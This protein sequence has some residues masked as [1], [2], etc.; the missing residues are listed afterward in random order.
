MKLLNQIFAW[1]KKVFNS[2]DENLKK[3]LPIGIKIVNN[4]KNFIYDPKI[5]IAV[6]IIPGEWDNAIV[7]TCRPLLTKIL[8]GL[9]KWNEFA[10]LEG[11]AKN[12]AIINEIFKE[13]S[14]ILTRNEQN[15][16]KT[17]IAAQF[18]AVLAGTDDIENA[19]LLT[20]AAYIYPTIIE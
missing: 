20:K 7:A 10:N 6:Q 2:V 16:Y 15:D 18:N 17:L 14:E 3:Y 19:K 13:T 4:M 1:F 11:E 8:E 9:R 5:D 12:A